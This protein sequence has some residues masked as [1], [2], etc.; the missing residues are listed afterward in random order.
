MRIIVGM[1]MLKSIVGFKFVL[2]GGEGQKYVINLVVI[3]IRDEL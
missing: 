1:K 2:Q 3:V